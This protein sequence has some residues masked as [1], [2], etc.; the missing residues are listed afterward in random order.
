MMMRVSQE[1]NSRDAVTPMRRSRLLAGAAAT[2]TGIV[3]LC[4][5][6]SAWA[7]NTARVLPK[8]V[9]AFTAAYLHYKDITE[10]YGASGKKESRAVD[11]NA[12]L[13]SSIFPALAPL[14]PLVG[15]TATIGNSVVDSTLEYRV[16]GIG[17]SYGITDKLM[18]RIR[19]PYIDSKND[20]DGAVDPSSANVGKNPAFPAAG[21]PL[22][23]TAA[24]GVPLTTDDVRDLL[25]QG[26]DVDRNG[27]VDIPGFGYEPFGSVSQSGFG[28]IELL[29]KYKFHDRGKWR[30][31]AG[32]GA[33]LGTG[34]TDDPDNLMDIPFGD[35]QS[36]MLFRFYADYRLS[37]KW[38]LNGVFGY[39]W[40][41]P[42][43]ETLRV[44]DD[45]NQPVT[46]NRER[47]DRDLGN[48]VEL[49]FMARYAFNPQWG[50]S[51]TFRFTR[52]QKDDVDGKLGFNYTS[53][54]DETDR[55][56][57]IVYLRLEYSTIE[58]YKNKQSHLPLIATLGY[59]NRY[60]GKNN[61][62][63]SEFVWLQADFFF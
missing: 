31:A 35:G 63:A 40:Q 46:T 9:S 56:S 14:D 8:G 38:L 59:R 32:G 53:L 1:K 2:A 39:D 45:V 25:S 3:L 51:V 43:R 34:V 21:P 29:F 48:V 62:P 4:C 20:V 55:E 49:Q 7:D 16:L 15:G 42:D 61:E 57:D 36:D 27:T 12:D 58:K 18:F 50:T 6:P 47:V 10:R 41:L 30:L 23:P 37:Q 13:N 5:F 19:V 26:L 54:E 17:Y 52:K 24:G 33:R 60:A 44:L 22:I 11:Y 28:D